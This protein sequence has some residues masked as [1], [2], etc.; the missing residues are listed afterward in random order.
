M[1]TWSSRSVCGCIRTHS[2]TPIDAGSW[3]WSWLQCWMTELRW[4]SC[5]VKLMT[6]WLL[7]SLPLWE[8]NKVLWWVCLFVLCQLCDA[9]CITDFMNVSVCSHNRF[10]RT[11]CS[12]CCCCNYRRTRSPTTISSVTRTTGVF[13]GSSGT[14]STRLSW[15]PSVPLSLWSVTPSV[16]R[17]LSITACHL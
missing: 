11:S 6:F 15:Q 4:I 12:S 13:T 16:C 2:R 5:S 1:N 9:L 14:C 17:L 10:Y 8:G 7:H 3:M